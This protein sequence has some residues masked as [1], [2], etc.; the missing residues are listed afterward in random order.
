MTL[1]PDDQN[2]V[3][4]F[5]D[6]FLYLAL[7]VSAVFLSLTLWFDFGSDQALYYYLAWVWKNYRLLPYVGV[8]SSDFPGIIIIHRIAIAFFG[9]SAL[10]FRIFDFLVQI[11]S[12]AMIYYFAKKLSGSSWA[13]VMAGATYGIFYYGLGIFGGERDTFAF[14]F[15]MLAATTGMAMKDGS[16]FR[17]ILTGLLAGSALMLKPV[18]GLCWSVFGLW[19]LAEGIRQRP[20]HVWLKLSIFALACFLP[21]LIFVLIYWR[22]GHLEN[23]YLQTLW[24][25]LGV[26][27]KLN[28]YGWITRL[29]VYAKM[30]FFLMG[31]YPLIFSAAVLGFLYAVISDKEPR[32]RKA[33]WIL[34]GLLIT[35][36]ACFLIHARN[37]PYHRDP[38]MGMASIFAGCGMAWVGDQLKRR[39]RLRLGNAAALIFYGAILL[40]LFF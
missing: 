31:K 4:I 36:L 17:V 13:G 5:R 7:L 12:V 32:Q 37:S 6:K 15:L 1:G 10:G 21:L 26:Y 19:F 30:V 40:S 18:Y 39:G 38:V 27:T 28:S 23:F 11:S 3:T 25:Q 33:L 14:W 8:Y 29:V 35:F 24:L 22:Q 2:G 34:S 20:L 16:F 9:E